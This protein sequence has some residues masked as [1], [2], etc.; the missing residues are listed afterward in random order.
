MTI[1]D[2]LRIPIEFQE[3]LEKYFGTQELKVILDVGAC[4]GLDSIKY[5]RK[6]PTS[7]VF[8]FEPVKSN[9]E[10]LQKN[11]ADFKVNNVLPIPKALGSAAGKAIIHLSSGTPESAENREWNYGNKSSSLLSPDK[12]KVH[13]PWMSFDSQEEVEVT[14][15]ADVVESKNLSYIDL[16]H[17][18][19]QGLELEVLKGG[20][21]I[22]KYLKMI[23]L[24]VEEVALYEGQALKADIEQF[25]SS[26]GFMKVKDTVGHVSGD[27]LW[28]NRSFFTLASIKNRFYTFW[29]SFGLFK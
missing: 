25:L 6:Y 19:V 2:Y 18:D 11:L 27:Q 8:S 9:F 21:E 24:E 5:A 10:I 23:W 7:K 15:L 17:M 22:G 14:T 1:E 4:E 28:I 26:Q 12:V 20:G 13:F 3:E 29:S 16:I